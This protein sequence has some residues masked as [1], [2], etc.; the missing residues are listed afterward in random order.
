[1]GIYSEVLKKRAK[2]DIYLEEIA[3]QNLLSGSNL[4]IEKDF[5]ENAKGCIDY[6]LKCFNL[7]SNIISDCNNIESLLDS[8]LDPEWILYEKLY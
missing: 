1:M 5:I 4:G 8:I 6:V 2:N 7:E 3:D